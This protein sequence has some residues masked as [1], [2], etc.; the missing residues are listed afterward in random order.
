MKS[1]VDLNKWL[2]QNEKR[3]KHPI[4]LYY[5]VYRL[6]WYDYLI[7]NDLEYMKKNKEV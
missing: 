6:G 1:K 5:A 7:D 3:Y 4:N 2:D